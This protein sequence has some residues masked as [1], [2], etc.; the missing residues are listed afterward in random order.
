MCTNNTHQWISLENRHIPLPFKFVIFLSALGKRSWVVFCTSLPYPV[1]TFLHAKKTSAHR[2][3]YDPSFAGVERAAVLLSYTDYFT[4]NHHYP[5]QQKCWHLILLLTNSVETFKVA[6][7]EGRSAACVVANDDDVSEIVGK[8]SAR[9]FRFEIKLHAALNDFDSYK[10]VDTSHPYFTDGSNLTYLSQVAKYLFRAWYTDGLSAKNVVVKFVKRYGLEVHAFLAD[11]KLAPKLH[12]LY[13]F[14]PS[15]WC[16]TQ[17]PNPASNGAVQQLHG[18]N[19]QLLLQKAE[20]STD[21]S[22]GSSLKLYLPPF[23][24]RA[25]CGWHTP[26]RQPWSRLLRHT[27]LPHT[28]E[29]RS[30][31]SSLEQTVWRHTP[32]PHTVEAHSPL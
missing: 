18:R 1:T 27:S 10:E 22:S 4:D 25:D 21:T 30:P 23:H 32:L 2:Y 9:R 31:P 5:Q 8:M 13:P 17:F 15:S 28:V 3:F 16:L 11:W 6:L 7:Q 24:S 12:M 20:N 19:D 29:A 14:F 26:F